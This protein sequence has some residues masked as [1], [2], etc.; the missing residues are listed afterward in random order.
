MESGNATS[1]PRPPGQFPH[2]LAAPSAF[3]VPRLPGCCH[4]AQVGP[5][6]AEPGPRSTWRGT[7]DGAPG[8]RH[9]SSSKPARQALCKRTQIPQRRSAARE[10][11]PR[12]ATSATTP[13]EG[14]W[15]SRGKATTPTASGWQPRAPAQSRHRAIPPLLQPHWR[16]GKLESSGSAP[17]RRP[18]DAWTG[19]RQRSVLSAARKGLT[20][21]RRSTRSGSISWTNGWTSR[22]AKKRG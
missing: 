8:A 21:T 7:R 10:S 2:S 20:P 6:T 19:G 12:S 13:S 14:A 16:R 5:P 1:D 4:L 11:P 17:T 18:G 15:T 9:S 3:P 22:R